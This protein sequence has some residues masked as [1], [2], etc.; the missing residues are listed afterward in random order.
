MNVPFSVSS[1]STIWRHLRHVCQWCRS[2]LRSVSIAIRRSWIWRTS[3]KWFSLRVKVRM[4][5][6]KTPTSHRLFHSWSHIDRFGTRR[7]PTA[8]R[9]SMIILR[10]VSSN[11]SLSGK[12]IVEQE[13]LYRCRP[14]G[15]SSSTAKLERFG[16]ASINRNSLMIVKTHCVS[17]WRPINVLLNNSRRQFLTSQNSRRHQPSFSRYLRILSVPC[18][19]EKT[20]IDSYG[21]IPSLRVKSKAELFNILSNEQAVCQFTR[22]DCTAEANAMELETRTCS[23]QWWNEQ[24][25]VD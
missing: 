15:N 10:Q 16:F 4:L 2:S 14:S 11:I 22:I 8:I 25:N 24:N 23:T 3:A 5:L 17:C 6:L 13:I 18:R 20:M 21:L 12:S 7:H 9:S 19:W 1:R